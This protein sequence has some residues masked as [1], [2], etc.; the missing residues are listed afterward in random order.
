MDH[1]LP[2]A[3]PV[4][5]PAAR[6]PKPPSVTV[7]QVA[8]FIIAI[9]PAAIIPLFL[10]R[11]S[12]LMESR[13]QWAMM[14]LDTGG[15]FGVAP[16]ELARTEFATEFTII[17]AIP[18]VLLLLALTTA[19]GLGRRRRWSRIL[20]AIWSGILLL[21]IAAW[22]AGSV[23]LVLM[24]SGQPVAAEFS[25]GP[26]DPFTLNAIAGTAALACDLLLF[27]LVLKRGIRRWAPGR[28]AVPTG[29]APRPPAQ[30]VFVPQ[31]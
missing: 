31:R 17:Q 1:P 26:V 30:E 22:A 15:E 27:V 18:V 13:Q 19:V 3:Q 10:W 29:A 23:A 25:L 14:G 7:A 5:A 8:G 24:N 6:A 21:P 16:I 9:A 12:D 11:M 20:G 28:G 2:P 4:F